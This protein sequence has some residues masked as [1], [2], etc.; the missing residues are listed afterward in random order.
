LRSLRARE[1]NVEQ[2]LRAT[3]LLTRGLVVSK[4]DNIVTEVVE[5]SRGIGSKY[6]FYFRFMRFFSLPWFVLTCRTRIPSI[7]FLQ[8]KFQTYDT[9]KY[10]YYEEVLLPLL[11]RIF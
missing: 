11:I 9:L 4:P 5:V 1:V 3:L 10:R 6:V 2:E 7:R 8:H